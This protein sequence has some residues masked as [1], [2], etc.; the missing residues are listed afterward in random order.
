MPKQQLKQQVE[1]FFE[2]AT[3]SDLFFSSCGFADE[4]Y[5]GIPSLTGFPSAV[6][7]VLLQS[8]RYLNKR[9]LVPKSLEWVTTVLPSYSD[10]RFRQEVRVSRR[11]FALIL[12]LIADNPTFQSRCV[13]PQAPVEA[14]LLVALYRFGAHGNAAAVARVASRFAI[15]D[16]TVI[17][18]TERIIEAIVV[19]F[20]QFVTWPNHIERE[21][22]ST[23]IEALCGFP[24]CLG[25]LDGTDIVLEQKPAIDGEL[26]F[27]RKKRYAISAQVVV[28]DAKV[29]RYLNVGMPGSVH[30]SRV[31]HS[32]ALHTAKH[33][34][35]NRKQYVLA[36]NGYPCY[37][38]VIVPFKKPASNVRINKQFNYRLSNIRVK[39][40]HAIGILKA[41]FMSLR[42]L[43]FNIWE[44]KH[45]IHAVNWIK[46]CIILHN[47]L[48]T[49]GESEEGMDL[50][51]DDNPANE[52]EGA[53]DADDRAENL[54]TQKREYIK[55]LVSN[56]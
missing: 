27:N 7:L 19:L 13:R 49:E 3:L 34:Y 18:Y 52:G 16:G 4:D 22:I 40:E 17:L 32:M 39:V 5:F 1:K 26:Y 6:A 44:K 15:G 42:G 46:T 51:N 11:M 43:R 29:V 45:L 2:L 37:P 12:A 14:Q 8:S 53:A 31:F 41:R 36:D 35:F 33:I 48:T 55:Q 21:S 9:V 54:G 10:D 28:D 25:F 38:H 23:R 56:L 30:D 47:I 50:V 20:D 24:D